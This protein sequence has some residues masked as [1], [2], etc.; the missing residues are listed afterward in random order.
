MSNCLELRR[1]IKLHRILEFDS[2]IVLSKKSLKTES[3]RI[4]NLLK[5]YWRLANWI[6]NAKTVCLIQ[7][8]RTNWWKKASESNSSRTDWC[9]LRK[10]KGSSHL[11]NTPLQRIQRQNNEQRPVQ[12]TTFKKPLTIRKLQQQLHFFIC[13]ATNFHLEE[14]F[15]LQIQYRVLHLF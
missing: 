3:L 9:I 4:K 15:S 12:I 11:P 13:D 1:S 8:L 10:E 7:H 14:T 2:K 6:E 5:I